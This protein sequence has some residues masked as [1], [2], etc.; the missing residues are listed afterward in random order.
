MRCSNS[1]QDI[2]VFVEDMRTDS[3]RIVMY[4]SISVWLHVNIIII[5]QTYFII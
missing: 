3:D 4:L 1:L 5:I 2:L